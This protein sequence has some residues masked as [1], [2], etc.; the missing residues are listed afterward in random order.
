MAIKQ[1]QRRGEERKHGGRKKKEIVNEDAL[2]ITDG[3]RE[4]EGRGHHNTPDFAILA[5]YTQR[6]RCGSGT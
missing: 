6:C 1:A 3:K 2:K 4:G 5:H